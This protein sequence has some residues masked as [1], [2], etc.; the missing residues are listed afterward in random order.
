MPLQS[1]FGR[2]LRQIRQRQGLAQRELAR[3]VGMD[4]KTLSNIECGRHGTRFKQIERLADVLNV[5]VH[6]LFI[7]G[8]GKH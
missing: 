7:F 2:R 6:E 5:A 1:H 4:E 8:A 3:L